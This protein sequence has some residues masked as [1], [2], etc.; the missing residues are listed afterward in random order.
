MSIRVVASLNVREIVT[1]SRGLLHVKG[2]RGLLSKGVF[3]VER[4]AHTMQA[5]LA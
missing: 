2:G 4:K 1:A 3:V 5:S